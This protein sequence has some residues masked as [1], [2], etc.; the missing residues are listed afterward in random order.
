MKT[1]KLCQFYV[2]T[3]SRCLSW[4]RLT[5]QRSKCEHKSRLGKLHQISMFIAAQ[6]SDSSQLWY[7]QFSIEVIKAVATILMI[8]ILP[9]ATQAPEEAPF[10]IGTEWRQLIT[11]EKRVSGSF[12]ALTLASV[13]TTQTRIWAE[14][15]SSIR[16]RATSLQCRRMSWLRQCCRTTTQVLHQRIKI[17]WLTLKKVGWAVSDQRMPPRSNHQLS[18]TIRCSP[19]CQTSRYRPF[20][21]RLSLQVGANMKLIRSCF[22]KATLME[23]QK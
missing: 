6:S 18:F 8:A 4:A 19:L 20:L 14:T 10:S 11:I 3:N 16:Q 17:P 1:L 23:A 15:T 22:F 5:I 13:T 9:W 7:A 21:M 2:S 12:W